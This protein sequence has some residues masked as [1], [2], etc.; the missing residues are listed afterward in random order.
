MTEIPNTMVPDGYSMHHVYAIYPDLL[1]ALNR[2]T[3]LTYEDFTAQIDID[4]NNAIS[5]TESGRQ[6]HLAK[7]EDELTEHLISQLKHFYPSVNHDPQD[8]GHCDFLFETRGVDG[9]RYKWVME[10]KLWKGFEY[11]YSG[12]DE[13]LLGSYA[14]GG[15]NNCKGGLIFYSKLAKGALYAMNE[16]CDGL[17]SHAIEIKNKREDGLRLNTE[18]KLNGGVGADFYVNHYCIDLYHAPTAQV[19]AKAKK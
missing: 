16:W 18:H 7:S 19:I 11:V 3:P 15:V 5:F 2:K 1:A 12:L 13:Q 8:G 9:S 6:H 10:A 4:I 14:V 17:K